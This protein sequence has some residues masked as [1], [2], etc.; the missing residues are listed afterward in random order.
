MINKRLPADEQSNA[1]SKGAAQTLFPSDSPLEWHA[2]SLCD[3]SLSLDTSP[4]PEKWNFP[5]EKSKIHDHTS[6]IGVRAGAVEQLPGTKCCSKTDSILLN[7][8]LKFKRQKSDSI[9]IKI[10]NPSRVWSASNFLKQ[11]E[12]TSDWTAQI[13]PD[14][15]LSQDLVL[16]L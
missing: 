10:N 8:L 5:H 4:K 14:L 11:D 12:L 9:K 3:S 13:S 6:H 1:G 15:L 2:E 7:V 16:Y